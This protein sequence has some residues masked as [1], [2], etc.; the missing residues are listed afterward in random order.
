MRGVRRD[1]TLNSS[2]SPRK[3]TYFCFQ[4]PQPSGFCAEMKEVKQNPYFS[5]YYFR[6]IIL[7]P[8]YT[9]EFEACAKQ[10]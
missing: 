4:M 7:T 6:E 8:V 2:V 3:K 5:A 9:N 10:T 1:H